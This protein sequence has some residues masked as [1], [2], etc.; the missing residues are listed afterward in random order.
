MR[1]A[2]IL[3]LVLT[4]SLA[5]V[6]R[7]ADD[8][9]I[10]FLMPFEGGSAMGL[11]L[12][13]ADR[14]NADH[15]T[16]LYV[17]ERPGASGRRIISVSGTRRLAQLPDVPTFI[18]QGYPSIQA[19]GWVGVFAPSGT[20]KP[21]V[22]QWSTMFAK[23]VHSPQTAAR[24]AELGLDPTGTTPDELATILAGDIARWAP[25]VKASGFQAD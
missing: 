25:I 6:S 8:G 10:R 4:L 3:T 22:D 17:D 13:L 14:A 2:R 12:Y 19:V 9:P 1:L 5:P 23:I 7:A 21:V 20:P 18:E 16:R 11:A 24:F 15:G